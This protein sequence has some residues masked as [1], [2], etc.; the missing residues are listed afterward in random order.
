MTFLS[1]LAFGFVTT[2]TKEKWIFF[3]MSGLIGFFMILSV[4][5]TCTAIEEI[6]FP[7]DENLA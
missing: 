4:P 5:F 7:V 6:S 1:L 3:V 2:Y